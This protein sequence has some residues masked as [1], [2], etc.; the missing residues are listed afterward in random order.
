MKGRK[1]DWPS[2]Q[3]FISTKLIYPTVTSNRFYWPSGSEVLKFKANIL[4]Q[5]PYINIL[6]I[7]VVENED[8][9]YGIFVGSNSKGEYETGICE[10]CG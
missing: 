9:F 5:D 8:S 7:K 10:G 4:M 1:P 6:V 2:S 3:N